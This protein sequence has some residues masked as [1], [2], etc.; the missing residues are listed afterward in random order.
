MSSPPRRHRRSRTS[1]FCYKK[2]KEKKERKMGKVVK[3]IGVECDAVVSVF[4]SL[5]GPR[6]GA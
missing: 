3:S 6:K 1:V 2:K 5:D 4:E